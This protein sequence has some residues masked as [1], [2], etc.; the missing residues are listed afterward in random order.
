MKWH[1]AECGEIVHDSGCHLVDVGIRD[2]ERVVNLVWPKGA[3]TELRRDERG[4]WVH[5]WLPE[6]HDGSFATPQSAASDLID[7]V[8]ERGVHA[9]TGDPHSEPVALAEAVET[10]VTV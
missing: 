10:A 3:I 8:L 7:R 5:P 1:E 4:R 9:G 2:G 6:S